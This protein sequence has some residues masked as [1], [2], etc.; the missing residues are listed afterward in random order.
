LKMRT[1]AVIGAA[2][3]GATLLSFPS[4]AQQKTVKACTEE[5][6]ANKAAN[7]AKGVTLKSYVTQCRAGG[8]AQTQT[9][10]PPAS[11]KPTAAAAPASAGQKTI[12]ACTDEWR[13]NKDANQ[14][15]G[16]TL[17]AFV[18][19]CRA[20]KATTA[21][22]TL[23]PTQQQQSR[24]ATMPPPAAQAPQQPRTTTGAAPPAATAPTGANQYAT[25]G[26]AK[27][28]CVGGTVV[29]ANLDSK[30]YH[31][32][33]NKTYGQTKSG[34]YMCERDAQ[35]QGMRAAKNEKHP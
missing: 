6:R 23:F 32:S 19:D 35:G 16:V 26:Q 25:E 34:A 13:A 3:V 24:T 15:K 30:I 33:G 31:F 28:R 21:Q 18:A 4:I 17:K 20:G 2:I 11:Q 9:A 22:P 29:W 27:F 1:I 7:E 10:P 8:A 14:A 12:K 5:W